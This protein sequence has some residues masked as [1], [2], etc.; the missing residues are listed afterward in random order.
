MKK[1]NLLL[2]TIV[3]L[4]LAV[5]VFI[6]NALFF[7]EI[8]KM[9]EKY[10]KNYVPRS[11]IS[12]VH[13]VNIGDDIYKFMYV[14][15]SLA[16]HQKDKL[17]QIAQTNDY[18][19]LNTGDRVY[20]NL[21]GT[22]YTRGNP[23]QSEI[24]IL[25]MTSRDAV[26]VFTSKCQQQY[27]TSA[28]Y[29]KSSDVIQAN[30][31]GDEIVVSFLMGRKWDDEF[32]IAENVPTLAKDQQSL[33]GFFLNPAPGAAELLSDGICLKYEYLME[34]EK[35]KLVLGNKNGYP[36]YMF[37]VALVPYN[38]FGIEITEPDIEPESDSLNADSAAADN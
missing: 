11:R 38:K 26:V 37:N 25:N 36:G 23:V 35:K 6:V 2:W 13:P 17:N 14:S 33:K 27:K 31:Y 10:R 12:K 5:M 20:S 18:D 7:G 19:H 4:I 9:G 34:R 16:F 22:F 1:R 29:V 21:D 28:F 8:D 24:Q 3:G 15:M 30:I 32:V